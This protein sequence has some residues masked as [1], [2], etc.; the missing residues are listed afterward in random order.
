MMKL[1]ET[2]NKTL[3][4]TASNSRRARARSS[5]EVSAL[6]TS[7]GFRTPAFSGRAANA[8]HWLS[9]GQKKP[10]IVFDSPALPERL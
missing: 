9:R 3:H 7:C 1:G 5:A 10:E 4:Q 6:E 8:V 2:M